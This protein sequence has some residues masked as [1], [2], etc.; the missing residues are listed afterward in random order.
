MIKMAIVICKPPKREFLPVCVTKC[1]LK[2]YFALTTGKGA[3]SATMAVC[4]LR[5]QT[6]LA[7]FARAIACKG[8][9]ARYA[10][11]YSVWLIRC[12]IRRTIKTIVNSPYDKKNQN[13]T[14]GNHFPYGLGYHRKFPCARL[15]SS[16]KSNSA[17]Q[18][19]QS[20]C[21]IGQALHC[22]SVRVPP[23]FGQRYSQA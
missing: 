5:C 13:Q 22:S 7:R 11:R 6:T 15:L 1:T 2:F 12:P 23:Q 20:V 17:K 3:I 19:G 16:E 21:V 8:F 14:I 9:A 10:P 4:P 18:W